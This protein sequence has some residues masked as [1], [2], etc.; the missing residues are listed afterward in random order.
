VP[1]TRYAKSGDVNI[2]YQVAGAGPTDL[3]Y[4]PG[5]VSN[6]EVMWED[7]GLAQFMRRLASFS[8][9]IIFDKRGTGLS[10]PVG[11]DEL[12]T[13]ETRMDDLRAV[14]DAAGSDRA[15]LFGHSEGG[16]MCMLFAATYPQ[17]TTGLILTG[18]YAA[19][20]RS[21]D[22]PWAPTWEERQAEIDETERLWG[23]DDGRVAILAPGRADDPAFRSWL[24][25]YWRLSASPQAAAALLRMNTMIDV[26][27]I[28]S[29]I[30]VPTLLL[31]RVLDGDVS[32]EEGRYIASKIP[33]AR[34]VELPGAD[35]FFWTGDPEQMLGEIEQFV[36]GR[37]SDSGQERQLATVLFTDIVGST[38][39]AVRLGDSRWRDLI[40]RHNRVVRAELNQWRGREVGTTGDG[41]LATFDGPARAIRCAAAIV[42]AVRA[43]GLEVRCGLHTGEVEIVDGDVAGVAVH[44]GAR[45]AALGGSGEVLVSRTVRDLVAGAGFGFRSVGLHQLKGV[46]DEWEVFAVA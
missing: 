43:L 38:D 27:S 30:R 36:T 28:L 16:N 19:R 24:Q 8:R 10:D 2:A 5:W 14:M 46:P 15:F 7:P 20:I 22:Y 31:Y 23:R 18:S 9:L 25:R 35:H 41:F 39:T 6:I 42:E 4:V 12:P 3:V 26:T 40:E 21:E 34:L 44:I 45:I 33:G 29:S 32:V 17:R 11:V 37:R 1:D 13:L